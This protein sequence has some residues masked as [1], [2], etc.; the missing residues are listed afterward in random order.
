[1]AMTW[2][3]SLG[4]LVFLL[5]S[6]TNSQ[7]LFQASYLPCPWILF[8]LNYSFRIDSWV[9]IWCCR[10]STGSHGSRREDGTS[11]YKA[12]FL[13]LP[14]LESPMSGFPHL[15]NPSPHKAFTW[16]IYLFTW[17]IITNLYLN[18][19]SKI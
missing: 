7:I 2:F 8:F 12:G 3:L 10:A 13:S 19:F 16:K 18:T 4:L 1:M 17:L 15:P 5:P 14:T 11:F 6:P 9:V